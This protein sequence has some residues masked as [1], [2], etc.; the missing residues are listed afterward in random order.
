[1]RLLVVEDSR[2]IREALQRGLEA[3][4]FAV[5]TADTGMEALRSA[6]A[7]EYDVIV[8]DLM[9]P[10][11][12]GISF[13]REIRNEGANTNV[14]VVSARDTVDDRIEG[15]RAG[16]D[17]YMVKPFSFLELVARVRALTRRE[18]GEKQPNIEIGDLT[19]DRARRSAVVGTQ[20]VELPRREFAILEF[21]ALNHGRPVSREAL[22]EHIYDAQSQVWSNAV[23]SAISSLRRTLRAA[24]LDNLIRTR[25]G[26]GYQIDS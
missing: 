8:L 4:G 6:R 7:I 22:E 16:A 9:L 17:D 26:I 12:D 1:M 11:L 13:L 2:R 5:D 19:I 25:R 15:L 23:D 10:E 3:E 24:G 20:A 18:F 14:I 21:L